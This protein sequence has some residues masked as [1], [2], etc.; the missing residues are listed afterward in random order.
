ML[1]FK[2][3]HISI[4]YFNIYSILSHLISEDEYYKRFYKDGQKYW[5]KLGGY[6]SHLGDRQGQLIDRDEKKR[7]PGR[8]GAVSTPTRHENDAAPCPH[9]HCTAHLSLA[10]IISH[11]TKSPTPHCFVADHKISDT[12]L[13]R[14]P[15]RAE[16]HLTKSLAVYATDSPRVAEF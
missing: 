4:R 15:G 16:T 1:G 13:F 10:N 8:N 2:F 12:H 11:S 9:S 7:Q 5:S 6:D 3:N 14:I